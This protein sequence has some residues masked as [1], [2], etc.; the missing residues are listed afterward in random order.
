MNIT[1]KEIL[2]AGKVKSKATY[3]KCMK[4][5]HEYGYIKYD[6]T[7]NPFKGSV[8]T[9]TIFGEETTKKKTTTKKKSSF[10]F[11]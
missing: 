9:M 11:L 7:Y 3:H 1:R 6:P 2:S 4:E 8:I 10:A 5:L